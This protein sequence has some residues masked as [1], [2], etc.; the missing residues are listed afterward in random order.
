MRRLKW[1]AVLDESV[2]V[3]CRLGHQIEAIELVHEYT[4][5]SLRDAAT[6]V[7]KVQTAGHALGAQG[8]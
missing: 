3:L 4:D 8:A 6:Y 5:L 2:R 1:E 7:R